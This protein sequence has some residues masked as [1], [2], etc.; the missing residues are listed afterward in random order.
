MPQSI[1]CSS[2]FEHRR[3]WPRETF[4]TQNP[5]VTGQKL[6][7]ESSK[8]ARC[9]PSGIYVKDGLVY[10]EHCICESIYRIVSPG[11]GFGANIEVHTKSVCTSGPCEGSVHQFKRQ[12]VKRNSSHVTKGLRISRHGPER[13]RAW[14]T[15]KKRW[16]NSRVASLLVTKS[17]DSDQ[18]TDKRDVHCAPLA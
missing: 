13:F 16:R 10:M 14:C 1:H 7:V 2:Q 11:T 3:K 6:A 8:K 15:S 12:Q 5:T 9:S 17:C 4:T 18:D